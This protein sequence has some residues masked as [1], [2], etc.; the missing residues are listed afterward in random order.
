MP[1][2]AEKYILLVDSWY[3][4]APLP[5]FLSEWPGLRFI[6]A[7]RSDTA[8]FD[9][10][11]KRTGKRGRPRK[12]G[13]QLR[14]PDFPMKACGIDGCLAGRRP[15]MTRLFGDGICHLPGRR[16]FAPPVPEYNDQSRC[17]TDPGPSAAAV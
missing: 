16:Q 10:P 13:D 11:P 17:P 15:V 5:K 12:R 14:L 1:D 9:L 4:K 8:L 3:T 2:S 6:G 7:A